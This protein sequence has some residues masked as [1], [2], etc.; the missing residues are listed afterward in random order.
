MSRCAAAE[1][2]EGDCVKRQAG[3]EG[4]GAVGWGRFPGSTNPFV[5]LADT[6]GS[7]QQGAR[8]SRGTTVD[9]RGL[10]TEARQRGA[11][12]DFCFP[13]HLM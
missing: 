8:T 11:A 5:G 13:P 2:L 4:E 3:V 9:V 12:M 1:Y 7:S 6:A 10:A